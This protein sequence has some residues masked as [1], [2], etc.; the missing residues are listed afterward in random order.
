MS[1]RTAPAFLWLLSSWKD[2]RGTGRFAFGIFSGA[3]P[4]RELGTDQAVSTARLTIMRLMRQKPCCKRCRDFSLAA[5]LYQSALHRWVPFSDSAPNSKRERPHQTHAWC[6][7]H[8]KP[9]LR[10]ELGSRP[11]GRP[12]GPL[13]GHRRRVE[14]EAAQSRISLP[15]A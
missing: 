11:S 5:A 12:R 8:S 2:H 9:R 4:L 13:E 7:S 3:D 1:F 10:Q 6:R 15:L 14:P